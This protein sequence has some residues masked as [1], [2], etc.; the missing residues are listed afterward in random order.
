MFTGNAGDFGHTRATAAHMGIILR[1][2][3]EIV[4]FRMLAVS[5]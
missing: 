1:E 3:V 5:Q 4:M 2:W